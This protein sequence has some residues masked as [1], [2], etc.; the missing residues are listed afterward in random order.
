MHVVQSS[1][2][3]LEIM[4]FN[5]NK[6]SGVLLEAECL[7]QPHT[8]VVFIQLIVSLRT[9]HKLITRRRLGSF[10]E[11]GLLVKAIAHLLCGPLTDQTVLV[12]VDTKQYWSLW[13]PNSTGPCRQVVL[14]LNVLV[15]PRWPWISLQQ[16]PWY[17]DLSF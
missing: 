8:C 9:A 7:D 17:V 3:Q 1:I 16:S 2:R 5:P 14:Y 13:T 6:V 15:S 10:F 11:V 12:S 4:Y